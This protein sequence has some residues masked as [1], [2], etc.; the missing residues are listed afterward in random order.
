[1]ETNVCSWDSPGANPYTGNVPAAVYAYAE[2]PR[3][4]ADRLFARM[5]RHQFDDVAEITR[6]RIVGSSEYTDLRGMHFG[7]KSV[8]ANKV[9]RDKWGDRR[10]HARG[11]EHRD[12]RRGSVHCVRPAQAVIPVT[13]WYRHDRING[14]DFNHLEDGHA[15]TD[16]PTPK[17]PS[18]AGWV[19]ANWEAYHCWLDDGVVTFIGP[20]DL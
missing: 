12:K 6:D 9:T 11:R 20:N 7:K 5:S 3:E 17:F 18:Q 14:W 19:N 2:I 8:C 16:K 10:E 1:M 15:T 4:T 13:L